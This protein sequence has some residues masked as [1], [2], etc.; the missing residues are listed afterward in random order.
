MRN[1]ILIL[2]HNKLGENREN[3]KWLTE[4][5]INQ[6]PNNLNNLTLD[7]KY[8]FEMGNSE[9]IKYLLGGGEGMMK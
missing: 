7:L 3:F 9:N 8:N 4:G 6:L 1:L 5:I 2:D